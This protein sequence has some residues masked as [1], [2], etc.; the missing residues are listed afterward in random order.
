MALRING[1]RSA[2]RGFARTRSATLAP[3]ETSASMSSKASVADYIVVGC[4][5]PGRG[6]GWYHAHQ[7]VEGKCGSGRLTDV[8]EPWFLGGGKD[9][10]A[11]AAF[12]LL[13]KEW[14]PKG[15]KFHAS[16]ETVEAPAAGG[17][18]VAL[19]SGRTAD[20]PR[21]LE[22][23]VNAGS[24]AV[25][26]EKP[27]APTVG[28][29]ETMTAFAKA[30]EVPVF[31]G[32]NKNVTKYVRE[33]LA[34]EAEVGAGASTTFCA[35]N[36]YKPHELDEC[37]E[38]NAEGMLKNMAVHELALLVS[39][40]GVSVETI[41]SVK[42]DKAFSKCETRGKFTDFSKIGF[43]IETTAGKSV[44][45]RADRC[46]GSFNEALVFDAAG[47]AIGKEVAKFTTPDDALKAQVKAMELAEPGLMPYFYLQDEDY[48]TLK[49]RCCA[50][51]ASGKGGMP[52]G[53]AT[54]QIA[55]DTLKVAEYLKTELTKQCGISH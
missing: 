3:S 52:E 25:F 40:Y 36:A 17:Q 42:A 7:L 48:A 38:R 12:A 31:M 24:T 14:E 11:G 55:I 37:F 53:I 10:P 26:L 41:K 6:M 54:L 20:N 39:F 43:T 16:L 1:I 27:G 28:E 50:H 49:E 47:K 8:V 18:K 15:V 35:N 2:F 13:V 9:T 21:L 5:L 29:L 51:I 46:G 33:A 4:G 19:I 45:V 44:T 22:E 23:V 30:K 32:Y 34:K